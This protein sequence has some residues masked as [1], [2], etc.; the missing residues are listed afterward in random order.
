MLFTEQ[1]LWNAGVANIA[2]VDEV[3]MGPLAGPVVAAA[4]ILPR[5][6]ALDG[7]RDSK[8]LNPR[9]RVALDE[10]IRGIAL[11][12]GIGVVETDEVDRLNVYQAGL[13]AMARAV[14]ALPM[15]PEHLLVDARRIPE[16]EIA[17]TCVAQ[18]DRTV[19]SIAT[20]SIVAKV[21]RDRIM[22]DLDARYPGYGFGR[23]SG[24]ATAAHLNALRTLGPSPV[25]RRSFAPVRA[26]LGIGVEELPGS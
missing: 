4:V 20:A 8:L 13:A 17:Q 6:I 10:A 24:Y 2:G 26:M 25:H 9:Q 19:Y 12:I 3:G 21:H 5:D 16:C 15:V 7:V 14:A 18:G 1:A 23:H 22:A 11:G